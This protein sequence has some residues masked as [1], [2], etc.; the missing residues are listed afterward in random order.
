MG[1]RADKKNY[2]TTLKYI[3]DK[4]NIKTNSRVIPVEIPNT[5]REDLAKLFCEL[6]F[7]V[8]AEVGVE[9]GIYSEVL[10]KNN[11]EGKLFAVDAWTAYRGYVDHKSQEKLNGFMETAKNR[12]EKYNCEI[13]RGFSVDVAK[14]FEDNS[15][16]YV[17][18]DANHEFRYVV[19]DLFTWSKKVKAGGI[20]A[21]HDYI[22]STKFT[23]AM[24]V[25]EAVHAFVSCYRIDPLF[26]LGAKNKEEGEKRDKQRSWFFVK[27]GYLKL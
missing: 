16:D 24:H 1:K 26:V 9:K 27:P 21:G 25:V 19:D 2:D 18:L 10:C 15:L 20:I 23:C 12:L 14:Q 17:Y 5:D 4:F 6:G 7:K 3:L 8:G 11:P 13:I 22:R